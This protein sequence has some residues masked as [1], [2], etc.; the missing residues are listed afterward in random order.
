M[1]FLFSKSARKFQEYTEKGWLYFFL[2]QPQPND[3]QAFIKF[4]KTERAL[5]KRLSDYSS[6]ELYNIYAIHIQENEIGIRE[7][8]MKRI[9]NVCKN[10][11]DVDIWCHSGHE[12]LK[13]DLNLM[14]KIFFHF[15]TIPFDKATMYQTKSI[16]VKESDILEW[17]DDLHSIEHYKIQMLTPKKIYKIESDVNDILEMVDT[18]KESIYEEEDSDNESVLSEYD[19]NSIIEREV[20]ALSCDKCGRQ[21]KDKRGLSIHMRVC[22]GTKNFICEFCNTEFSSI[23]SLNIHSTRCSKY[24][25]NIKKKDNLLMEENQRLK[26]QI[27]VLESKKKEEQLSEKYYTDFNSPEDEVS[28][29]KSELKVLTSIIE[30]RENLI[31]DL[32]KCIEEERKHKNYF[33]SLVSKKIGN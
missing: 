11:K 18:K 33:L 24:K 29:L 4:G 26:K 1:S 21:C 6:L 20:D 13:G 19:E 27:E 15:C 16:V 17:L 9:F 23:Y 3:R 2:T 10:S 28:H 31:S 22:P 5:S 8:A 12:F 32:Y 7:G 30:D 25:D 14:M